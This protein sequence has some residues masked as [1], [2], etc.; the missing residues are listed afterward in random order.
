MDKIS[1]S[2]D[3]I[4]SKKLFNRSQ[5]ISVEASLQNIIGDK[6]KDVKQS[7]LDNNEYIR[8]RYQGKVKREKAL[9]YAQTIKKPKASIVPVEII[10]PEKIDG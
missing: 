1:K 3:S 6:L 2:I 10:H 5:N 9:S 4:N 8:R 7:V